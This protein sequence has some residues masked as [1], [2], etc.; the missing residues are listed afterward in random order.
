[1]KAQH[2][3]LRLMQPVMWRRMAQRQVHLS[4]LQFNPS[5]GFSFSLQSSSRYSG[6]RRKSVCKVLLRKCKLFS[7]YVTQPET[8]A[9]NC[10]EVPPTNGSTELSSPRRSVPTDAALR[11]LHVHNARDLASACGNIAPG[12]RGFYHTTPCQHSTV[13]FNTSYTVLVCWSVQLPQHAAHAVADQRVPCSPSK[14]TP[15]SCA[16]LCS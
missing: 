14:V 11:R 4:L 16:C 6:S 2:C 15:L 10:S 8:C 13:T 1:M 9:I 3:R 7:C 5:P 12:K